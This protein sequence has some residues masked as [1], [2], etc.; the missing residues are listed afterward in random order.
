MFEEPQV[1][2]TPVDSFDTRARRRRCANNEASGVP[3]SQSLGLG[4]APHPI[5]FRSV[6]SIFL[7]AAS[8]QSPYSSS[9][10]FVNGLA[11]DDRAQHFRGQDL[12][13]GN[14]SNIPVQHNQVRP[15]SRN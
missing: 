12:L 8:G 15:L 5:A 3:I 13:R 9:V 4:T 10:C 7:V 1:T 2:V 6:L 14:F 11:T